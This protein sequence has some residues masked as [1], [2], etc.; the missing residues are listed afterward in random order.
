RA[1]KNGHRSPNVRSWPSRRLNPLFQKL[2]LFW[3]AKLVHQLSSRNSSVDG[4]T[5]QPRERSSRAH[6][7]IQQATRG[8]AVAIFQAVREKCFHAKMVRQRAKNV[9]QQLPNQHD[10]VALTNGRHDL[11]HCLAAELWLQ[12]VM[13]ILFAEQVQPVAA[14][15]PQ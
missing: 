9:F 3:Q 13:K 7:R 8:L 4:T 14:D 10:L 5:R 2:N 1:S 15:S 6:H 11:F 12:D